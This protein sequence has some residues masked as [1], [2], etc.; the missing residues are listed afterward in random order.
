MTADGALRL[1][2]PLSEART[3]T[4]SE[5]GSKAL[6]PVQLA[7][8][9]LNVP[10]AY[11]VTAAAYEQHLRSAPLA[12]VLDSTLAVAREATPDDRC[13]LLVNLRTAIIEAPIPDALL[14]QIADACHQLDARHL[15]VRSSATLE[16]L[17][18]HSFAGLYDTV[19]GVS[20]TSAV[21]KAVKQC[22]ASL[23]T[24]RAF[25]YR[26]KNGLQHRV[27]RMAVIVQ[28][29][30][31]AEVAG[32]LFTADPVSGQRNR[33][34]V[35]AVF[36]L[37]ETLVSGKVSP[38]RFVLARDGFRVLEQIVADK[39][40]E[41]VVVDGAVVER[42]IE[43][44]RA[45]TPCLSEAQ[46]RQLAALALKA[47]AA[48][49]AP[50]DIEWAIVGADV[51]LLQSR[52]V[53]T[54][55]AAAETDRQVW[56]N[57]NAGEVVPDVVTPVTWSFIKPGI[58]RL[59]SLLLGR[60]GFRMA[61]HTL[62]GLVAGRAYFN[63]NTF[64]GIMRTLPGFRDRDVTEL[65]GGKAGSGPDIAPEDIPA[66]E[67]HW[68][69]FLTGLPSFAL[70]FLSHSTQRGLL[71]ATA[72]HREARRVDAVNLGSLSEREIARRLQALF[73][74]A[75]QVLEDAIA[76]GGT[77]AMYTVSL[78]TLC[79]Q[80]LGDTDGSL[81][82]GLLAGLG[83]MESAEA[84]LD[85]WRLAVLARKQPEVERVLFDCLGFQQA[86]AALPG[87]TGGVEFL[88]AWDR[89]LEQH[90]HH[91]RGEIE[92]F[93]AR[94]HDTPDTILETVRGYLQAIGKIDPLA[95]HRQR[96]EE[97]RRLVEECRRRLRNPLKRAIF[98]FVLG[99]AQ[100]GCLVRENVKSEAVR[101]T[102]R[103]RRLLQE[104]GGRLE[105][106]GL[107]T[108]ADD[109]FFLTVEELEPVRR[110]KANFDV[111]ATIASRRAEYDRNL[112]LHPPQVVI[113]KFDPEQVAPEM[114]DANTRTLHG[115]AVS[116]G[117]ATGPAR[118]ILRSDTAE[119]VLPGEILVAPFTD[120]GWT[121]YFLRAA[122]IVMDQG[123]LLSH[124]SIIAREYGIPAVVNVGPATRIV[125]TGQLLQVDGHRG[126]VTLLDADGQLRAQSPG[127]AGRNDLPSTA[128]D[129]KETG[130]Q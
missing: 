36:G 119:H 103:A 10:A 116:P 123:G 111:R 118:V 12:G 45:R 126:R 90:G 106:R 21:T 9:G 51:F 80:W 7:A 65:F 69:Q 70:W 130:T 3:S 128:T 30:I 104:L 125:R 1:V 41:A 86:R 27:A 71:F 84:G 100:R 16:D 108:K 78:L 77:G 113:G 40:L 129:R 105:S 97:R 94:W 114:I 17:P 23:W 127:E 60:F 43:T 122:G 75:N 29:L 66:F 76:F 2:V 39:T 24:E 54:L 53:T 63:L 28:R 64:A 37:G 73:A 57:L 101:W 102:A 74:Q 98:N 48:F 26:E 61:G 13:A 95:A 112:Q 62:V 31:D 121:P 50:Q 72:M 79:R 85:Q 92:F 68:G 20:G 58:E 59:F 96:G 82:H 56:S 15:A 19:L 25:E 88:A 44:S 5:V 35:E 33:L 120:P 81:A 18:H 14:G 11:C 47:E 67:F 124:G 46:A 55:K 34:V 93:N 42:P 109:L 107:L 99:N 87:V 4:H 117:V 110:G 89:F 91:A 32:V 6:N 8:A 22:W 115:L 49:G 52:P 38:D 83:K